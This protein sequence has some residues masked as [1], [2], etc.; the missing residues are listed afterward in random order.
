MHPG[1]IEAH[2]LAQLAAELTMPVLV[3]TPLLLK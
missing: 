3:S 2:V 1:R